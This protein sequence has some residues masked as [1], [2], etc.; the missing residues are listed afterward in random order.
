MKDVLLVIAFAIL[1]TGCNNKST[2]M[3]KAKSEAAC[4]YNGGAHTYGN[5]MFK[6][7]CKDGSR[8][9]IDGYSGE[10]VNKYLIEIEN[11]K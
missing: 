11:Q 9:D 2:Q 5:F 3:S 7:T 6:A 4:H 1:A 10:L 8:F